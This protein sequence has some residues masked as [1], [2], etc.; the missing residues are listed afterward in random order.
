ME[1]EC[2]GAVAMSYFVFKTFWQIDDLDGLEG[3]L[4][5]ALTAT[6]AQVLAEETDSGG[7]KDFDAYLA[8]HVDWTGLLAFLLA[9]LRLAFI[10]IDNGNSKLRR[11]SHRGYVYHIR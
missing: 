6:N 5:Y 7:V 3:T 4:L 1:L 9:L 8:L 11:I 10:W 2:V